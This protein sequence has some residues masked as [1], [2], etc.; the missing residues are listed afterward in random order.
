MSLLLPWFYGTDDG[1]PLTIAGWD[2]E[3]GFTLGM[4]ACACGIG[5][6]ALLYR[7]LIVMFSAPPAIALTI[8]MLPRGEL[9]SGYDLGPGAFAAL[10]TAL[11]A[12]AMAVRRQVRH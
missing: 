1:Q 5:A 10:A 4:L 7:P 11:I 2:T 6:G 12:F 9:Y 8:W 3:P